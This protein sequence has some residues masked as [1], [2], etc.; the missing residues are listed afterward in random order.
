MNILKNTFIFF[1]AIAVISSC[2]GQ[3]ARD[4]DKQQKS[5]QSLA[6][7]KTKTAHNFGGW[8]CPDNLG[9]FPPV[10]IS[11][12]K[13]VQ[14]VQDRLP[15]LEEARNGT[16]LMYIDTVEY[17]NARPLDI[18][19]PQLAKYYSVHSNKKEIVIVIQAVVIGTDTVVGFRFP[20]GGNGS[21]WYS[22]VEFFDEN[23]EIESSPFVFIDTLVSG[24]Q[25]EI[26]NSFVKTTYANELGEKFDKKEYFEGKWVDNITT[27]LSYNE[28]D[29]R[30]IG[31]IM[32]MYGALYAQIDYIIDGKDYTEKIFFMTQPGKGSTKVQ[33]SAG[34]APLH[35]EKE[36]IY[37][38]KFLEELRANWILFSKP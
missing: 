4:Q 30:G 38:D 6:S 31:L 2:S 24:T 17:P 14:V 29:N 34:P 23:M 22:E 16:S 8:Y 9:G 18:P 35:F 28:G 5:E 25:E 32:N 7:A 37:W 11:N 27:Q 33:V 26:W 21:S 1:G 3:V 12:L 36:K 10:D 13:S 15:T 19:L 20:S